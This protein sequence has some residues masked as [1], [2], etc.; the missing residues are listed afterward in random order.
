MGYGLAEASQS[1]PISLT[2]SLRE[3]SILALKRPWGGGGG[4][5]QGHVERGSHKNSVMLSCWFAKSKPLSASC[6]HGTLSRPP[7]GL[8]PEYARCYCCSVFGKGQG[9]PTAPHPPPTCGS[10][11]RA[12]HFPL[13]SAEST[14]KVKDQGKG[15][16]IIKGAALIS[17]SRGDENKQNKWGKGPPAA[18]TPPPSLSS[19]P[20]HRLLRTSI[21]FAGILQPNRLM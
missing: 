18:R 17:R 3:G 2:R 8:A 13:S 6:F 11:N 10:H 5:Q 19:T 20:T 12:E 15:L 16:S 7:A 1:Q 21:P 14:Q 4:S 9:L